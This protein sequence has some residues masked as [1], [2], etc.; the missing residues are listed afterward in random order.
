MAA[1]TVGVRYANGAAYVAAHPQWAPRFECRQLDLPAEVRALAASAQS[2]NTYAWA[3]IDAAA[4][5]IRARSFAPTV[6]IAEDEATGSAALALCAQLARPIVVHQGRG[7]VL[8]CRPLP[9]GRVEVGGNV[10]LD[11]VREHPPSSAAA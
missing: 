10:T 4:G 7:S 9:D 11:L 1:G 2:T 8:L 3:W 5:T 6:G